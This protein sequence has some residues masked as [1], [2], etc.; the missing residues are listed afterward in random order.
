MKFKVEVGIDWLEEDT[1][2]DEL[3]K[4]EVVSQILME[5]RRS[6]SGKL[7]SLVYN[8]CK[9]LVSSWINEELH[10]FADKPIRLTDKWGDTTE[11]HESLSD[12]FKAQFDD[13]LNTPVDKEGK[14]V[15]GCSYGKKKNRVDWLMQQKADEI[16]S[17]V[18][19]RIDSSLKYMVDKKVEQN[20][21]DK[22]A[23]HTARQVEKI[24]NL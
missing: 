1:N 12:M 7:E 9:N 8:Q 23:E 11:H 16:L 24:T 18:N 15:D 19:K 3:I 22:I 17:A 21:K 2:I 20:I 5:V 13:F 10:K 4:E 14:S 6:S